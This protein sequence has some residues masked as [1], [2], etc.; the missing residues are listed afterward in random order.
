MPN[1]TVKS[2]FNMVEIKSVYQV[3]LPLSAKKIELKN[4][5][6]KFKIIS[7]HRVPRA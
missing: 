3:A 2:I 4:S 5:E 7:N 6:Q 1:E